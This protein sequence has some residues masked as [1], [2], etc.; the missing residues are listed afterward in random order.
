[1]LWGLPWIPVHHTAAPMHAPLLGVRSGM[2]KRVP[3]SEEQ[4]VFTSTEVNRQSLVCCLATVSLAPA[5]D[6][7]WGSG[8][9]SGLGLSRC[10]GPGWMPRLLS[11]NNHKSNRV[12]LLFPGSRHPWTRPDHSQ[13]PRSHANNHS[14]FVS[15]ENSLHMQQNNS[16]LSDCYLRW[17]CT[18]NIQYQ[19]LLPVI[20]FYYFDT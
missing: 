13:M 18:C 20:I 10:L 16:N 17:S 11:L 3:P 5:E 1:M 15:K 6:C 12:L 2:V 9:R 19:S 14:Y 7:P 8:L 4:V